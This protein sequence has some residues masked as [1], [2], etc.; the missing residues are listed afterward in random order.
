ML[1]ARRRGQGHR[2][3]AQC[4]DRAPSSAN[5]RVEAVALKDGRTS[6]PTLVVVAAGIRPNTELARGAGSRRQSRHR[7]R[8]PSDDQR[9][10]T[11]TPSA[12][13]PSIAA[14][15]TAWSSRPTSRRACWPRISPGETCS[16]RR[17]RAR[18]QS[19]G[20]RRQRV[21]GRRFPRRAPAPKQIV[22]S[23]PGLGTYKKLVIA[24]DRLIG[25]VLFGDTADGALVSRSD[26]LGRTDRGDSATISSSA[27]R[28]PSAQAA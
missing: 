21:L 27:A 28:L 12:N 9:C 10:R 5:G 26:P 3:P 17:Q 7:R 23:D 6:R 4:R 18:D 15:A 22:L 2:R 20:L 24:D 16:Y 14:S 11:S 25:A 1:E 8:R 13:A 19:E